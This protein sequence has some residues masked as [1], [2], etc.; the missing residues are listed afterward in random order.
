MSVD[1][2]RCYEYTVTCD[3]CEAQEVYHTG[4]EDRGRI[5]HSM[6]DA[7]KASGYRMSKKRNG[8]LL[9]P[10]CQMEE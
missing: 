6:R 1:V 5:V 2:M 3:K 10:D 9:C 4:D 7:I 8:M